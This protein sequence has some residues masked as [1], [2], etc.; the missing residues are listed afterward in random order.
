M[1]MLEQVHLGIDTLKER[2]MDALDFLEVGVW[3]VRDALQAAYEL[4]RTRS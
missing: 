1:E 2:R 3:Q 4:G